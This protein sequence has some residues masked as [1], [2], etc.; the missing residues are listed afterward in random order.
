VCVCEEKERERASDGSTEQIFR[1]EGGRGGC[2]VGENNFKIFQLFHSPLIFKTN[3]LRVSQI[4]GI[5]F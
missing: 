4:K 3:R 2:I 5:Y 1:T